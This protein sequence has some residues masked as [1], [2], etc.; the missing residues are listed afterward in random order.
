MHITQTPSYIVQCQLFQY[1]NPNFINSVEIVDIIKPSLKD[2]YSRKNPICGKPLIKI[3]NYGTDVLTSLEIQYRVVG[4]DLHNYNWTGSLAFL[5]TE[6]V[7]RA[8]FEKRNYL[9]YMNECLKKK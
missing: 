4:G 7:E 9:D 1:K 2:E 8:V 5:E 3:R 6:E